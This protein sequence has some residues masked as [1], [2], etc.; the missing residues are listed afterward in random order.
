VRLYY[1]RR[2]TEYD[3]WYLGDGSF[4]GQERPGWTEEL[5]QLT[6]TI[7]GLTPG[8]TL[9]VGCGTGF[10]TR[11]LGGEVT[12]LDQSRRMLAIAGERLSTATLVQGEATELPFEADSFD[13]VFTS[14]VYGHLP[15][16]ERTAFLLEARRVAKELV[17]VD[18][19]HAHR[20]TR[21]M[22]EWQERVLGD[23]SSWRVY[24]RYFTA[25][26]LRKELGGGEVLHDGYWF[27]AV[28]A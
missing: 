16:D 19:A 3:D 13:R 26:G 20:P 10:L 27:V 14:F 17:V 24:K 2:A 6:A 4:A 23:G 12:A 9:D 28:R 21:P 11:H 18:S 25:C 7:R 15:E 22:A 8:R 5:A 1:D